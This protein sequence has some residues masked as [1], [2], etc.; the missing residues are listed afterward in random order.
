VLNTLAP[1]ISRQAMKLMVHVAYQGTFTFPDNFKV[2][3]TTITHGNAFS[4]ILVIGYC[5]ITDC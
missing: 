4:I 2:H 1:T 3:C 5:S